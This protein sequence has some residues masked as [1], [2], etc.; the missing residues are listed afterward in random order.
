MR[1]SRAYKHRQS[2]EVS[3]VDRMEHT[4]TKLSIAA[5]AG[6]VAGMASATAAEFPSFEKLGFPITAHQLSVTGSAFVRERSPSPAFTLQGMPASPHQ[7]M[8]L[9]PRS[10][11]A[12]QQI[13][14]KPVA[15]TSAQ[16]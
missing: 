13:S 4:M 16:N 9:T 2:G 14:A 1:G 15:A 10:R 3:S 8:V 7:V 12:E 11:T 5:A 6:L